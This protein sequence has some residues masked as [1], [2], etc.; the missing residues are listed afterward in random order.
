MDDV[1][2]VFFEQEFKLAYYLKKREEFE[3]WFAEIME[4]RFPGDFKRV[5][6]W[7]SSGDRKNDGYLYSKRLCFRYMRRTKLR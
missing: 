1:A 5:R 2:H 4:L 7:G 3:N 6:P